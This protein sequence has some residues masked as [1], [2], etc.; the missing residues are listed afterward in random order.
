MTYT[1][2]LIKSEDRELT[3]DTIYCDQFKNFHIQVGFDGIFYLY[4]KLTETSFENIG[5]FHNLNL[6]QRCLLETAI[7][8]N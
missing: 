7:K 8:T 1:F 3:D 5:K 2:S 6:A 4:K